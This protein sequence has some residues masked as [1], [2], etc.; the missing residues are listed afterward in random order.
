M[1][2]IQINGNMNDGGQ[3]SIDTKFGYKGNKNSGQLIV[4]IKIEGNEKTLC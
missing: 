2:Q 4:N 3:A 1:L